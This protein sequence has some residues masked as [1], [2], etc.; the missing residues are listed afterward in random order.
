L[1]GCEVAHIGTYGVWFRRGCKDYRVQHNRLFDLGAGGIRLGFE[2]FDLSQ[3]GLY[4]DA[5]WTG[6]VR[7]ANSSPLP[8]PPTAPDKAAAR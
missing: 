7:H 4:G 2:P 1:E 8:L 6:E 3:A 5:A